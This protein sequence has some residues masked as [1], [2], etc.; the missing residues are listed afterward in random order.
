MIHV[1]SP[2]SRHAPKMMNCVVPTLDYDG[3]SLEPATNPDLHVGSHPAVLEACL[4]V[5]Q[6]INK[7]SRHN[8]PRPYPQIDSTTS[9]ETG[10]VNTLVIKPQRPL[11][12]NTRYIFRPLA[13]DRLSLQCALSI[14]YPISPT[15]TTA[16]KSTRPSLLLSLLPHLPSRNKKTNPP[17]I[18]NKTNLKTPLH[19]R[20]PHQ[21][22]P[23]PRPQPPP[24]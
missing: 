22:R 2:C 20:R 15:P 11:R 4:E 3:N 6:N 16:T 24:R 12:T 14:P 18:S 9:K 8:P 5:S 23:S 17:P 21:I 10:S 13:S 7:Y 1:N 19:P